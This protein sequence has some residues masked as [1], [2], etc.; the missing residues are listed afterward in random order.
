MRDLFLT[1]VQ[2]SIEGFAGAL[3]KQIK[4]EKKEKSAMEDSHRE[5]HQSPLS[6][7]LYSLFSFDFS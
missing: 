3:D 4:G 7:F 1:V 6:P 5:L 2:E